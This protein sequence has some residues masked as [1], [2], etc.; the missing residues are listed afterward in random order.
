MTH[1]RVFP[2][3]NNLLHVVQRVEQEVITPFSPA[4]GH[5]SILVHTRDKR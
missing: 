5:G 1:M 2:V 4:D 3:E